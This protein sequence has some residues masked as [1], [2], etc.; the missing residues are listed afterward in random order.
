MFCQKCGKKIDDD[1]EFCVYC[2]SKLKMEIKNV[3]SDSFS[4]GFNEKDIEEKPKERKKF[5]FWKTFTKIFIVLL[6]LLVI[7]FGLIGSFEEGFGEAFVGILILSFILAIIFTFITKWRKDYK[8]TGKLIS[9]EPEGPTDHTI[10]PGI[11]DW[12]ILV[13]INLVIH[14]LLYIY[15]LFTTYL[16]IFTEGKWQLLTSQNSDYYIP[17]IGAGLIFEVVFH[18]LFLIFSIYLLLFLFEKNKRFPKLCIIY[19]ISVLVYGIID[20]AIV[21]SIVQTTPSLAGQFSDNTGLGRNVISALVWVPYMLKS[22]LVK[23]TFVK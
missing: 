10:K 9:E 4:K 18:F 16:P 3:D 21:Q 17:G 7:F 1:S 22:K 19:L 11:R 6:I 5:S 12:L 14:P 15:Y 13:A 2:G 20:Y 23:A 8:T